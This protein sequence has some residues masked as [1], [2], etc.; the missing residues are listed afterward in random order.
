MLAMSLIFIIIENRAHFDKSFL[1]FGFANLF[2]ASFCGIDIWLQPHA[3][4]I[5]YTKIQHLFASF[6]PSMIYWYLSLLFKKTDEKLLKGSFVIGGSFAM[7]FFTDLM[8]RNSEKEIVATMLYNLTFAPYML[9]SII[10]ITIFLIKKLPTAA[11]TDRTFI[12]AHLNGIGALSMGGILDMVTVFIGHRIIPAVAAFS[13]P[14][15]LL[16]EIIVTSI[17]TGRLIAIIKDRETTFKKLQEAYKEMEASRSLKELGQSTAIIN[18]EIKNYTMAI[19][20]YAQIII[21]KVPLEEKYKRMILMI[22]EAANKMANFSK[23]I[24]EFSRAKISAET[25][26]L[27]ILSFLKACVETHFEAKA[28]R[29]LLDA[30]IDSNLVLQG[31]GTKM[32]HVFINIFKNAFEAGA[33]QI[34]VKAQK[35][36]YMLLLILEDNGTGC[37]EEQVAS[38]FKS[39][40]T[41][42]KNS[43][44]TGLGLS[45]IR[46]I[47][48][49]HGGFIS[50]YSKNLI[51]NKGTGLILNIGF[52]VF[53][54]EGGNEQANDKKDPIILIQDKLEFL[55]EIIKKFQ[56]AF[57]NPNVVKS[58]SDISLNR[59]DFL[60]MTVYTSLSGL[61][62]IKK[63]Y[64]AVSNVHT[65]ICK[66]KNLIFVVKEAE[67][68]KV[69]FLTEQ[70]IIEHIP[71]VEK[72]AD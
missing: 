42:K 63:K 59:D 51:E 32:E 64:E 10:C 72:I 21:A 15:M 41:T 19:S 24:L 69:N 9:I 14:G 13:I 30:T 28:D 58:V 7:L 56:H 48:E 25:R 5:Y 53:Q 37:D 1:V 23:E 52:P 43:G 6:F 62:Q 35:K 17:F 16:F 29:I 20:G 31:D 18:H 4:T 71:T 67:S 3:Q 11:Q 8:L 40:Y 44:G 60:R 61:E 38:L 33:T 39:F 55:P 12:I 27:A 66:D 68:Q 2:L 22:E 36:K 46:S 65:I 70:Y 45:I 26:P 50:A 57:V 54:D 49:G 47:V 34:T